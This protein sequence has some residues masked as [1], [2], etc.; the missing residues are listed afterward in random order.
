[1]LIIMLITGMFINKKAIAD[2]TKCNRY[3]SIITGNVVLLFSKNTLI[4]FPMAKTAII[5]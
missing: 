2:D 3:I 4:K 5:L 1:M